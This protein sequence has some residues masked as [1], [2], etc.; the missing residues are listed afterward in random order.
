MF[1]SAL[2]IALGKAQG[3]ASAAA[4][5]RALLAAESLETIEA[6]FESS[7]NASKAKRGEKPTR[8]S[9]SRRSQIDQYT[10]D[11]AAFQAQQLTEF[12][13]ALSASQIVAA[14]AAGLASDLQ[15]WSNAA[16]YTHP[17]DLPVVNELVSAKREL[18]VAL[19]AFLACTPE[20][21]A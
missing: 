16:K 1:A 7:I 4:L 20:S 8:L 10:A 3:C 14:L 17:D 6:N 13:T 15:F 11:G 2:R 21:A 19:K 18:H 5:S 12:E 9:K